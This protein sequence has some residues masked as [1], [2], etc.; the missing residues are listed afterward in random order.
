M[1]IKS[2]TI[3]QIRTIADA[4]TTPELLWAMA[5]DKRTGVR[6][7]YKK[8]TR[9]NQ[10]K[11][12]NI[13]RLAKMK[14]FEYLITNGQSLAAGVDE[15]GRGP[16]AGPVV[17]AAVIMPNIFDPDLLGLTKLDDSK[18]IKA[19]QRALL[20]LNIKQY[21]VS[22]GVGVATVFEIER[23]NIHQATLLAMLRAVD[24]LGFLPEMLIVDGLFTLPGLSIFQ[25]PVVGGDGLCLS[26]AAASVIAKVTRDRLMDIYH[27]LYPQY[28]FNVHKGYG[29]AA[30]L[31]ALA[32]HGPCPLHRRDFAPVKQ[33]YDLTI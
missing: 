22:W 31:Q 7:L 9:I 32:L 1:D 16:L 20:A 6:T 21:A 14:D 23:L 5:E 17:A 27:L 10:K 25:E 2:L 11:T 12:A 28:G 29:T 33:F 18:R 13:E 4:G 8:Y 15:A 19:A 26:V 3:A 24:D 30:H